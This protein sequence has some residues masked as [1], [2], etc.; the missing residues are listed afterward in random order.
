MQTKGNL[1]ISAVFP[2]PDLL[3]E[4][5]AQ[6]AREL[7]AEG[8]SENTRRSYATALRYW[9]CWFGLRYGRPLDLPVAPAAV[10]QFVVDHAARATSEGLMTEMPA[11][12]ETALLAAGAKSQPGAPSLAT[13]RH[14]IAVLS[15]LHQLRALPNP[16][17]DAA[18]RELLTAT[19]R[20]YAKR[21]VA[22]RQKDALT[23][24]P[25][26]AILATCDCS[27]AGRRDRA[28]L[29]FAW[30]SGGRRRTEVAG[31]SLANLRR[32][33]A[34]SFVYT[35]RHSKTNQAGLERAD[36]AKPIQ[37]RAAIAL[38]D[39]LLAAGIKE[40]PIFRRINRGGAVGAS[41][42][43]AAVRD[44][45]KKRC[46]LAGLEGDFAAHS[47]RSGFVTE[48]AQQ[49]VPI[50]ETMAMTG[51]RSVASVVGYFRATTESSRAARLLD[52][53]VPSAAP[54]GD[55]ARD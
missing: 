9:E 37:G 36:N 11:S 14:R 46:A 29:L 2:A 41:L 54:A 26:E 35:L 28:L 24:E 7:L 23:R 45:V 16:C 5:A 39:W 31:A 38:G 50:A 55:S 13:L 12:V 30:A 17:Q 15:R 8:A 51:H 48:A 10:V 20:A 21:G 43:G 44:I 53:P 25:F 22:P 42:S 52:G 33:G 49:A 3:H 40:G 6:A 18:V 4:G 27:L 19:R 32:T 47:L 34:E 1:A